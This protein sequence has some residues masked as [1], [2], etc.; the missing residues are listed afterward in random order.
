VSMENEVKWKQK[1]KSKDCVLEHCK[2]TL[3][4]WSDLLEKSLLRKQALV[5]LLL[6]SLY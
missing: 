3:P 5:S 1:Q 2:G 6:R 4:Y